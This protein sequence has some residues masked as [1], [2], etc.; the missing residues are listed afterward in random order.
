MVVTFFWSDFLS[1]EQIEIRSK[2][3][4]RIA[5]YGLVARSAPKECPR[6]LN[7]STSMWYIQRPKTLIFINCSHILSD[8]HIWLK[9]RTQGIRYLYYSPRSWTYLLLLSVDKWVPK[10]TWYRSLYSPWCGQKAKQYEPDEEKIW[11]E[12]VAASE[13]GQGSCLVQIYFS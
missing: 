8:G 10:V 9:I 2:S 12:V 4:G 6:Y 11:N 13:L 7:C 3:G 1:C 5:L